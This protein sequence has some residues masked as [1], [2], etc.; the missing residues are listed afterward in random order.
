MSF[1]GSLPGEASNWFFFLG[2]DRTGAGFN[3]SSLD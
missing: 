2:A 1:G 3:P